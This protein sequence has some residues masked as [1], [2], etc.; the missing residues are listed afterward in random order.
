MTD[1]SKN[2]I[3]FVHCILIKLNLCDCVSFSQKSC[4]GEIGQNFEVFQEDPWNPP[5]QVWGFRGLSR[6]KL[7]FFYPQTKKIVFG[8]FPGGN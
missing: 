5:E 2:L 1:E 8:G 3:K 6:G 7:I 4:L